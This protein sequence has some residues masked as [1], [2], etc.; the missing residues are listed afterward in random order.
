[1]NLSSFVLTTPGWSII[2]P[3]ELLATPGN[4]FDFPGLFFGHFV[5]DFGG[6]SGSRGLEKVRT[7][8]AHLS[9]ATRARNSAKFGSEM[10][11]KQII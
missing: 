2:L 3:E 7:C 9:K 10:A 6:I 11:K 4:S 1:M 8:C 5:P